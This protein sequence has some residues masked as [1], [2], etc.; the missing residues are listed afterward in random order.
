M[1]KWLLNAHVEVVYVVMIKLIATMG[2]PD[3]LRLSQYLRY[4]LSYL[5]ETSLHNQSL[6]GLHNWSSS[7]I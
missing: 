7:L 3:V 5:P 6:S 4:D 2:Q 1:V